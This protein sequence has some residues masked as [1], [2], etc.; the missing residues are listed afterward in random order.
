[1]RFAHLRAAAV[2]GTCAWMACG[3]AT[4][5][6][7]APAARLN[8][9]PTAGNRAIE[10]FISFPPDQMAGGVGQHARCPPLSI[11]TERPD[12]TAHRTEETFFGRRGRWGWTRRS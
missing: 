2:C 1:M 3:A 9:M 8:R 4:S 6:A 7:R 5:D 10:R 11:Q 12:Q